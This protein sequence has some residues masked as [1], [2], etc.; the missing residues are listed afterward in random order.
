MKQR[1]AHVDYIRGIA[2]L[3][4]M[5]GHTVSNN[6]MNDFADSGMYKV[7]FALQMPLFMLVSGYVTKYSRPIDSGKALASFFGRRSLCY[8]L[9][10]GVWTLFRGFA[11]GGWTLGTVKNEAVSLLWNMDSGYWFLFSLW[12]IC[13]V[14][15]TGSFIANKLTEKRVPRV[16]LCSVFSAALSVGLFFVGLK[17]GL[18]FLNIKLTLYYIPFFFLGYVF[19]SFYGTFEHGKKFRVVETSVAAL[20]FVAFVAITL[21]RNVYYLG[22]SVSEISIRIICSLTGCISVIFF[23]VKFFEEF[24]ACAWLETLKKGVTVIGRES[25]GFYLIHYLFLNMIRLPAGTSFYSFEAF[26]TCL[27][28]YILTVLLSAVVIYIINRCAPLKAVLFGK[29]KK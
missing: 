20:S 29:F 6:G 18:S 26:E 9:P 8:L 22:E 16:I 19:A 5:L 4:V 27:M 10:W 15:G 28:N 13:A 14:W 2:I 24:K 12:T 11:F 21:N 23:S 3:L 1:N 7:I 25:L 17:A